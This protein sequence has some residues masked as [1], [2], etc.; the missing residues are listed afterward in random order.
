M[1]TR[2]SMSRTISFEFNK[3]KLTFEIQ[4]FKYKYK[5]ACYNLRPAKNDQTYIELK[6][7]H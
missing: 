2:Y 7:H 6:L 5:Y 3:I 1:Y 4:E